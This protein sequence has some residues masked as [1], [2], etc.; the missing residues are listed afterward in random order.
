MIDAEEKSN[1]FNSSNVFQV[2]QSRPGYQTGNPFNYKYL[3]VFQKDLKRNLTEAE[4]LL[5]KELQNKKTGYKF[6][7]Q[8]IISD[9][10]VDFVCLRQKLVVEVDGKVHLKQIDEDLVRTQRLNTKGYYVIRFT[11][12]EVIGNPEEIASKIKA[13]IESKTF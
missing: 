2:K 4:K 11:N 10:I 13:F 6:R 12:E 5:W 7:R 8:H 3:K 1:K 9:M